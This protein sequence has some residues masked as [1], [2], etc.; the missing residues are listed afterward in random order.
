MK[1]QAY[2]GVDVGSASV[3][4]GIF[5]GN[6]ERLAFIVKPIS[7]FHSTGD[8]VEQSATEIWQ[9][10]GDAV[11][12][13]VKSAAIDPAL[14]RSIGFDATCSLVVVA[15]DGSGISVSRDGHPERDIMM[16]M[17]H[18]AQQETLDINQTHD[19]ALRYVGGEVSVE[20]ELPKI[21]W[22]KRH[23][24]E[25]Y[26]QA[27]RLFDLADYLVWRASGADV[28]SICTLTCKWN[29]LA[30]EQR[31]STPLLAAVGLED[32]IEKIPA[33]V[34]PLGAKAGNLQ[35]DVAVRWGLTED[36]VVASGIIDA[37]AGGLSLSGSQ[38]EGSLA[39]IS[40]TSNC[41]MIVSPQ[42]I[43]IPGVWGPYY[44]AMLPGFWLNEG[45][46]SAAG[47]LVEW[48]LQQHA[49]WPAVRQEASA[50]GISTYQLL[51]QW[52][53]ALERQ[54]RWPTR[55]L[56]V[57]GDHHG[58]RSPR[59]NPQARGAIYGLTLETG[60]TGL[61]RLYLATLQAIAYGTRHIIEAMRDAGHQVSRI[62]MCGGATKNPLWLREYA[63]ATGCDIH[64][65][66]EDDAVTLGAALLG[67]VA[68][69]DFSSFPDA[70]RT[71]SHAGTTVQADLAPDVQAFHLA[72]YEVY[73]MMYDD[74]LR[75]QQQ[76]LKFMPSPL[77]DQ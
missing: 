26:R 52:V 65:A 3:R 36:V 42:P 44:G 55:Q 68:C 12:E 9:A 40:G 33:T 32:A 59:A 57:L 47:A 20:M 62:M 53:D 7:Q 29:Y 43:D 72:K 17:D 11:A 48:T 34:L 39:I 38:P 66:A 27:W 1:G 51:N 6:G 31:F 25:R 4:A 37:H 8:C 60:A 45:G 2:I 61:A 24:P 75:A 74:Q 73:L 64:L 49:H 71:M 15:Q 56:H 22:L 46:Q 16:W 23:F 63:N 5:T 21:L 19:A 54:E 10:I 28:A 76:F 41:H 18:R 77:Q 50:L 58:N 69:G 70:V 14:I 30:H 35:P 13:C 67:S